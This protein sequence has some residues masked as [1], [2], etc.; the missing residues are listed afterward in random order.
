MVV[1]LMEATEED[2][3]NEVRAAVD[4]DTIILHLHNSG[5]SS[6]RWSVDDICAWFLEDY[7]I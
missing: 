7:N 2:I 1:N 5:D 6:H 3:K 4:R